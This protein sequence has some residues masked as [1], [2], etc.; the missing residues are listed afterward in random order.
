ME[1]Y[2]YEITIE[3]GVQKVWDNITDNSLS[4][5]WLTAFSDNIS[6]TGEWKLGWKI[7]FVDADWGTFAQIVQYDPLKTVELKHTATIT[8]DG[9]HETT[10]EM[11]EKW[12]GS[13]E[14]YTLEKVSDT[15]VRVLVEM[16]TDPVFREMFTEAW[17]KALDM[18]KRISEV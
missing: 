10:W 13:T 4:K 14:K 11:T 15:Q 7:S 12:I 16:E 1:K 6:A 9:V 2:N 5:Q 17:P 18:L 3:A 8:K